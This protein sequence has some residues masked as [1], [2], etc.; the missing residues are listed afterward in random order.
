MMGFDSAKIKQ[1]F[2]LRSKKKFKTFFVSKVQSSNPSRR[3]E[4]FRWT[5]MVVKLRKRQKILK[6][7]GKNCKF[8]QNLATIQDIDILRTI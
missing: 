5:V 6:N 3:L 4:K 8:K 7:F 2:Q 1:V